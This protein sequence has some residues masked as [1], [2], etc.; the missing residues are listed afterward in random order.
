MMESLYLSVN[1]HSET[2]KQKVLQSNLLVFYWIYSYPYTRWF[3]C[4]LLYKLLIRII[5]CLQ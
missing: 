2:K 3:F 4:C 1:K 5:V